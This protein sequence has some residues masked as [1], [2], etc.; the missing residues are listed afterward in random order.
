[1]HD[2]ADIHVDTVMPGNVAKAEQCA[3]P[4]GIDFLKIPENN[5]RPAEFVLDFFAF[6]PERPGRTVGQRF[7]HDGKF[8]RRLAN[9]LDQYPA[10][11]GQSDQRRTGEFRRGFGYI[12]QLDRVKFLL[13]G[14]LHQNR[15]FTF[16]GIGGILYKSRIQKGIEIHIPPHLRKQYPQTFQRTAVKIYRH[17]FSFVA[18]N[19]A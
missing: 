7:D 4:G 11:S 5:D 10:P 1:M 13:A 17:A 3:L 8:F 18:N 12:I 2:T 6:D 9:V 15:Q 19:H 16:F 14:Q